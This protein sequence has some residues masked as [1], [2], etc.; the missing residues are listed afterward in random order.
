MLIL[1][2]HTG[3]VATCVRQIREK[4]PCTVILRIALLSAIERN[5]QAKTSDDVPNCHCSVL[6]G[7]LAWREVRWPSPIASSG[8]F[9]TTDI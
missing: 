3:S 5:H 8:R 7:L 6:P 1:L 2:A 9:G 4:H